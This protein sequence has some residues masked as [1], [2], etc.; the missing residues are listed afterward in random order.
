VPLEGTSSQNSVFLHDLC[1][2]FGEAQLPC[3]TSLQHS[4]MPTLLHTP[5]C[6]VSHTNCCLGDVCNVAFILLAR[7][8]CL[9]YSPV[10]LSI[11]LET[12]A[13]I[14]KLSC[15]GR[16]HQDTPSALATT[17]PVEHLPPAHSEEVRNVL[18]CS[19]CD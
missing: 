2:R 11:V 10:E 18:A 15:L 13:H 4:V 19:H 3:V 17:L 16:T 7:G 1:R 6:C 5:M 12:L 8:F 14:C 9:F